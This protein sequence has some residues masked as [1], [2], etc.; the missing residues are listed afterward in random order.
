MARHE[1]DD[2]RQVLD[3]YDAEGNY[4]G[5]AAREFHDTPPALSPEIILRQSVEWQPS[6]ALWMALAGRYVGESQLDNTG[7]ASLTTPSYTWVELAARID[8]GRWMTW[9]AP[10]LPLK[11]NHSTRLMVMVP[12][13]RFEA[14]T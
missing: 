6:P 3:V 10:G 2:W 11:P 5:T 1:I 7:Q 9:G 8:L 12:A 4:A 14:V 13:P